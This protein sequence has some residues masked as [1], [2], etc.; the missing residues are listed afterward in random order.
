MRPCSLAKATRLPAKETPAIT[1]EKTLGKAIANAGCA[2]WL[3][4][5]EMATNAAAPPPTPL[6]AATICGI[7]VIF[8][9]RAE[10]APTGAPIA[11]PRTV[12]RAPAAVEGGRGAVAARGSHLPA[13]GHPEAGRGAPGG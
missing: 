8:T 2:L 4:S 12:I 13:A 1:I 5:S 3:S 11:I 10:I 6:N 9:R 7:A